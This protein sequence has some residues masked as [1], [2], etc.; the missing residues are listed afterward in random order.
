MYSHRSTDQQIHRNTWD[1]GQE[2]KWRATYHV[3]KY[4]K[5]TTQCNKLLNKICSILLPWHFHINSKVLVWIQTPSQSST[6][7]LVAKGEPVSSPQPGA[8]PCLFTS[9]APSSSKKAFT[10]G[11]M[12][13]PDHTSKFHLNSLAI[14]EALSALSR[15]DPGKRPM[16][17]LKG[18]SG[19]SGREFGVLWHSERGWAKGAFGL[20]VDLRQ[21]HL[22]GCIQRRTR[23]GHRSRI[24]TT[25]IHWA[26]GLIY[27]NKA[28]KKKSKVI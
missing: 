20:W 23:T 25:F 1:P 2:F 16:Q 15:A 27:C 14:H 7:N 9:L 13:F 3:S 28:R 6:Q 22:R 26:G 17:A 10:C 24:I 5:I 11:H 4:L 19:L 8:H 12:D 18:S 21:V